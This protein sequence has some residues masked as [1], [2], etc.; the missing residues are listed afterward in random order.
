MGV[1]GDHVPVLVVGGGPVGLALGLALDR[2]GVPS[3]WSPSAA[4]R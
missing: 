4:P 2:F 1:T 3:A